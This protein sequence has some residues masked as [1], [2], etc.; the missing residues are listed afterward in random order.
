MNLTWVLLRD[1]GL[2]LLAFALVY[3]LLCMTDEKKR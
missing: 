2:L 1:V 3:L